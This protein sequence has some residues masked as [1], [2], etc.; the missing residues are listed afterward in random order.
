M[1]Q[2]W[3]RRSYR[4]YM[5][6][7]TKSVILILIFS[8]FCPNFGFLEQAIARHFGVQ[9][10]V[11]VLLFWLIYFALLFLSLLQFY[12]EERS[13]WI[14]L[15]KIS[16]DYSLCHGILE[17]DSFWNIYDTSLHL[18]SGPHSPDFCTAGNVRSYHCRVLSDRNFRVFFSVCIMLE[19][20]VIWGEM[21]MCGSLHSS[22]CCQWW[23]ISCKRELTLWETVVFYF[24]PELNW[25]GNCYWK[26]CMVI[27][28]SYSPPA[29]AFLRG[30]KVS[31]PWAGEHQ[32]EVPLSFL[33]ISVL[34]KF[35]NFL[36]IYFIFFFPCSILE[37]S[38]H[39]L[40]FFSPFFSLFCIKLTI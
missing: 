23:V 6:H 25:Y 32:S 31:L 38:L 3:K 16:K 24:L 40:S 7:N 5:A 12:F 22:A 33:Y 26:R 34:D 37:L 13:C 8:V 35:N 17:T 14:V 36:I 15:W 27:H 29:H 10:G 39:L 2:K 1:L 28:Q 21:G 11:V 19:H 9:D 30:T 20:P 18:F 4:K